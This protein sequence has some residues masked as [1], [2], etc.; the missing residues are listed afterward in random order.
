MACLKKILCFHRLVSSEPQSPTL[1]PSE[2]DLNI[3][4]K[5]SYDLSGE[6]HTNSNRNRVAGEIMSASETSK[7][8]FSLKHSNYEHYFPSILFLPY[9][10][11]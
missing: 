5:T 1:P 6:N 7:S 10:F 8:G 9:V 3:T 11:P 2:P 4:P